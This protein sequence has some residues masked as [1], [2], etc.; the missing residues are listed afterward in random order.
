M[1]NPVIRMEDWNAAHRALI[2]ARRNWDEALTSTTKEIHEHEERLAILRTTRDRQIKSITEIDGAILS[3]A[4]DGDF[5]AP[6]GF[7][8]W[9][10]PIDAPVVVPA[11]IPFPVSADEGKWSE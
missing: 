2:G 4:N 8:I 5:I 9:G 11:T 6:A 10:D 1:G 3:G 7:D